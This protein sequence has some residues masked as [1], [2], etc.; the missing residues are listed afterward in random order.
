M[1]IIYEIILRAGGIIQSGWIDVKQTRVTKM[2]FLIK[3]RTAKAA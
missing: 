2:D 3:R 1:N